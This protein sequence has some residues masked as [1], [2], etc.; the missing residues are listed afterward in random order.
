MLLLIIFIESYSN[1]SYSL[2]QQRIFW[3]SHSSRQIL[4]QFHWS[5]AR[6][7]VPFLMIRAKKY[8]AFVHSDVRMLWHHL[9]GKENEQIFKPKLF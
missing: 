8:R 5:F 4:P 6:D 7:P 2:S 9:Q 3:T 1:Y